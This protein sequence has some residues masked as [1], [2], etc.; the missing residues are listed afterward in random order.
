MTPLSNLAPMLLLLLLGVDLAAAQTATAA[1]AVPTLVPGWSFIRAVAAPNFHSYLQAQPTGVPG[2][3]HLGAPDQ[4]GQFQLSD[5]QLVYSTGEGADEA[6]LYL[7]S[8]EN[9]YGTFGFQ[10]DTLIWST[11]ELQRPNNAAWLVCD[12]DEKLVYV[13]TGAYGYETPAGCADQTI[14]GYTG[15]TPDR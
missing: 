9:T 14:H 10:G 5:G 6:P 2:D 13:N 11:P 8:T 7:H 4:A 1:A 12:G 3:A 15:S